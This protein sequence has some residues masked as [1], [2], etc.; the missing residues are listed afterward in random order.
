MRTVDVTNPGKLIA[1]VAVLVGAFAVIIVAMFTGSEPA[2]IT[3]MV[4]LLGTA[5]GYIVGN[6]A[7]AKQGFVSVPP[8]QPTPA[9]QAEILAKILE[10]DLPFKEKDKVERLVKRTREV[11][12]DSPRDHTHQEN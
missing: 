8:F 6:G 7:G 5:M 12:S 11:E 9:R 4:G 10:E 3:S 1:L 2:L